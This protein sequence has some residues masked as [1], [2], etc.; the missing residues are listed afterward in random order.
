MNF[1]QNLINVCFRILNL[2]F[3]L[4]FKFLPFG[5]KSDKFFHF[6]SFFLNHRRFPTK[7]SLFNDVLYHFKVGKESSYPLQR[8]TTEK[9]GVKL[10]VKAVIG[11]KYNV[12]TFK[13]IED[14]ND[15]YSFEFPYKCCVKPT[16]SCGEIFLRK[17]GEGI[18]FKT[19]ESWLKINYYRKTREKNYKNL[20]NKLIVEELLEERLGE[21][22][23]DYK[24]FCFQGRV[25]LIQVTVD[26][27]INRSRVFYNKN[28]EK[29]D[30]TISVQ[31]YKGQVPKP[32]NLDQMIQIAEKLSNPFGLV[33]I[34]LLSDGKNCLVGEIT[35]CHGQAHEPFIPLNSEKKA[36]ELFLSL[37]K[38]N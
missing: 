34:D 26:R 21:G 23:Y 3:R 9:D 35:H 4:V 30:F 5:E 33:R 14:I 27:Y 2:I 29:Q 16:N 8:L 13:V 12:K 24:V 22:F 1:L 32:D 10:Y 18:P 36:S 17:N 11:E 28:W 15:L 38:A 7:K 20:Q 19:L 37:S 6:F 31:L 25:N